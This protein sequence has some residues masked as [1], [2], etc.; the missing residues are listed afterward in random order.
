[1]VRIVK[2]TIRCNYRYAG[3]QRYII[4][5]RFLWIWWD[6]E[7]FSTLDDAKKKL[8]LYDGSYKHDEVIM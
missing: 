8:C 6:K 1:M 7:W 5:K 2:R 4:Q 3:L